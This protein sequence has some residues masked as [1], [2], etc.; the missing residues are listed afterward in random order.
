MA[1]DISPSKQQ[2]DD[3]FGIHWCVCARAHSCRKQKSI[4]NRWFELRYIR[5][6]DIIWRQSFCETALSNFLIKWNDSAEPKC[7]F[8]QTQNRILTE[9]NWDQRHKQQQ[10]QQK[11]EKGEWKKKTIIE[12]KLFAGFAL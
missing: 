11:I 2:T 3:Y 10:Q 5:E 9:F 8:S 4:V 7:N 1:L 6:R 12:R